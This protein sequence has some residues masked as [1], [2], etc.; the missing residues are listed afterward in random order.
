MKKIELTVPSGDKEKIKKLMDMGVD[1]IYASGPILSI[2]SDIERLSYDE[3]KLMASECKKRK[4]KFQV[5]LNAVPKNDEIELIEEYVKFL[6]KIGVDSVLVSDLGVFQGVREYTNIKVSIAT[7]ASNT[8]WRAV[9]MWYKM[10]ADSV[11]IDRDI[12]VDGIIE[13]RGKVPEIKLEL[14]VHGRILL[15]ISRRKIIKNYM[16]VNSIDGNSQDRIYFLKEETRKKD[17]MPIYEDDNGTYI[18]NSKELATI[19]V[20]DKLLMLGIDSIRIESLNRPNENLE[21]VIMVYKEGLNSFLEGTYQYKE[22]W[23]KRLENHSKFPFMNW[24]KFD[25]KEK[26]EVI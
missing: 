14:F 3:L 7:H 12:S 16:E 20:L 22:E 8:N 13:I 10:G 4:I 18:Y 23:L 15:A 21:E 9:E 25:K 2:S 5:L 26:E 17:E 11:V 19:E 1:T 24:Y 6:E